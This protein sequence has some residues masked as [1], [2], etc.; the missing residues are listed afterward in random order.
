MQLENEDKT[1]TRYALSCESLLEHARFKTFRQDLVK[2]PAVPSRGE[3][4]LMK[5]LHQ[6]KQNLKCPV[7]VFRKDI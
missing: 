1:D 6:Y 3:S 2:L 4:W 7:S 5:Y